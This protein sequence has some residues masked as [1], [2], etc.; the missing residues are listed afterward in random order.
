MGMEMG[1]KRDWVTKTK[2]R[3]WE[4]IEEDKEGL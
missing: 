4:E 3:M 2:G 1:C